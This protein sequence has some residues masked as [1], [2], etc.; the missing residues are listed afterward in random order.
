V[1]IVPCRTVS[2][3][4]SLY[5]S[6]NSHSLSHYLVIILSLSLSLS[7]SLPCPVFYRPRSRSR[8]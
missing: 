4:L 1:C 3:R 8:L 2:C 7:L 5:H 6:P